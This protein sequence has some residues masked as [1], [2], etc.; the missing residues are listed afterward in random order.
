MKKAL[1]VL[2]ITVLFVPAFAQKTYAVQQ[3]GDVELAVVASTIS[4]LDVELEDDD[5]DVVL[6]DVDLEDEQTLFTIGLRLSTYLTQGWQLGAGL[7][8][9]YNFDTDNANISL[10]GF[11]NYNFVMDD[12]AMVPYIGIGG[13]ANYIEIEDEDEVNPQVGGQAGVKF[14]VADNVHLFAELNY[15][16]IYIDDTPFDD[17]HNI[18][19]LFG[20]GVLF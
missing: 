16:Y 6:E 8:G 9:S 20:V 14:Y 18:A 2:L 1:L 15:R 12:S 19:G 10:D 11:L 3:Q 7:N 13:G 4:Y 5:D 17:A